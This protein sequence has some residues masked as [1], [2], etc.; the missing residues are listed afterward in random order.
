MKAFM[1]T[2]LLKV[3]TNLKGVHKPLFNWKRQIRPVDATERGVSED[4]SQCLRDALI[5]IERHKKEI[6]QLVDS[7]IGK[8]TTKIFSTM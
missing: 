7:Y 8:Q 1:T 3:V 2:H 4:P 6:K 5:G